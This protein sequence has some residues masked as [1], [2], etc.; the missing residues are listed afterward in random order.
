M[1]L[2]A[3]IYISYGEERWILSVEYFLKSFSHLFCECWTEGQNVLW[4]NCGIV[5]GQLP[6]VSYLHSSCRVQ[7]PNSGLKALWQVPL[8]TE[9]SCQPCCDF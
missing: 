4:Y 5:V 1:K 3:H 9:P 8:P 6:G 2:H 7:E